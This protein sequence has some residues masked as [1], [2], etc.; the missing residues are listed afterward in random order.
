MAGRAWARKEE[1]FVKQEEKARQKAEEEARLEKEAAEKALLNLPPVDMET[2]EILT[3]DVVLDVPP[4]PEEEWVEPEIILPQAELE[5]PEQEETLDDEDV[6]VD[7]QPR[8]PLNTNF[9]A[10]NF[11]PLINQKTSLKRRKLSEKISK[12]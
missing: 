1:R 7:F 2:G 3:E 4:V 11:L 6:Q 5:F 12:S 10:Y 9:Q 8:R